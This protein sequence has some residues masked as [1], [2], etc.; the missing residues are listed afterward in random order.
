MSPTHEPIKQLE[1]SNLLVPLD[2]ADRGSDPVPSLQRT[3][4]GEASPKALP[5]PIVTEPV[6]PPTTGHRARWPLNS[7]LIV[8]GALACLGAGAALPQLA[9]LA[10]GGK[11]SHTV[12]TA[13]R[14]APPA[15]QPSVTSEPS[16][17]SEPRSNQLAPGA[18]S[19]AAA[20]AA[21]APSAATPSRWIDPGPAGKEAAI[22]PA[23][24]GAPLQPAAVI[25][26]Q[27]L[28]ATPSIL[29]T[30]N[31][32][33]RADS[34]TYGRSKERAQSRRDSR[35]AARRDTGEQAAADDNVP[36]TGFW[37]RRLDRDSN[38]DQHDQNR[39]GNDRRAADRAARE[40]KREI[41]RFTREERRAIGGIILQEERGSG[42]I[43]RAERRESGRASRADERTGRS[44]RDEGS[45]TIFPHGGE[46]WFRPIS[47][48][49]W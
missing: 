38:R 19:V 15:A 34:A 44:R 13:T 45:T 4:A 31:S 46:A 29:R 28:A 42:R 17:P 39:R 22:D 36:F 25:A 43:T 20:P 32:T 11:P 14:P 21:N 2:F 40:E 41:E 30:E 33:G 6:P 9:I 7:A 24:R 47:R 8:A 23:R 48:F 37:A 18:A 16:K 5:A 27:P 26:V 49:G 3:D 12:A 35:R 10:S 1:P